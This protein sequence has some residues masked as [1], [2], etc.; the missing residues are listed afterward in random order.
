MAVSRSTVIPGPRSG[1]W[2]RLMRMAPY[3]AYDPGSANAVR[4]GT[5]LSDALR[6]SRRLAP[7]FH[8]SSALRFKGVGGSTESIHMNVHHA[9]HGA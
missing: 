5:C 3:P 4:D 7:E 8:V 6:I 9:R 1:T 2:D